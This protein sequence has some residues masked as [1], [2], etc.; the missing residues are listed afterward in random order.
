MRRLCAAFHLCETAPIQIA[1]EGLKAPSGGALDGAAR[2]QSMAPAGGQGVGFIHSQLM[3]AVA[4]PPPAC[5]RTV[6]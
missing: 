1:M 5:R 2:R 4:P 3:C 6:G